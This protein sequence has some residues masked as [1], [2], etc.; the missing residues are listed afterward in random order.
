MTRKIIVD[1][2]IRKIPAPSCRSLIVLLV[3]D[4][5]VVI[6]QSSLR[7]PDEFNRDVKRD[8]DDVLERDE[9]IQEGE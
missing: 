9:R 3:L 4:V 1:I 7:C 2:L 8:R 5:V 6:D